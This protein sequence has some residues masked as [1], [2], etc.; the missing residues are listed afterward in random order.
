MAR[1]REGAT[2]LTVTEKGFGKRCEIDSYPLRKRGG[3]GI[4]R[5]EHHGNVQAS[6]RF[7]PPVDEAAHKNEPFHMILPCHAQG[8]LEFISLFIDIFGN[9]IVRNIVR[10]FQNCLREGA[11]ERVGT[12]ANDNTDDFVSLLEPSG[13]GIADKMTIPDNLFHFFPRGAVHVRA[14]IQHPADSGDRYAGHSGYVFDCIYFH[15]FLPPVCHD[16]GNDNG[17][18]FKQRLSQTGY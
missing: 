7:H 18:V 17:N 1:V 11:E 2:L 15:G 3:F 9:K 6:D 14:M 13:V 10:P 4:D 5:G 16:T 8:C 12:A